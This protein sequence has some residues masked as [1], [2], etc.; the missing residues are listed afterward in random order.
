[1]KGRSGAILLIP[2]LFLLSGLS[3]PAR[4]ATLAEVDSLLRGA[5]AE[6]KKESGDRAAKFQA[7]IDKAREALELLEK[8]QGLSE[9]AR[10]KKGTE[11]MSMIYWSRKMK[12]LDLSGRELAS[13]SKTDVKPTRTTGPPGGGETQTKG[14]PPEKQTEFDRLTFERA[15]KYA[16]R[17]PEDLEGILLRFEGI[18]ASYPKTKW[19]KKA[20]EEAE[21]SRK[22]LQA[23]RK[24]VL[25][26][27]QKQIERLE[28][29]EAL[30]ALDSDIA[31]ERNASRKAQL[32]RLKKDVAALESCWQR[33]VKGLEALLMTMHHPL[34]ELGIDRKGWILRGGKKGVEVAMR[35]RNA[36]P[37][38]MTW[39]D[40]GAAPTVRLGKKLLNMKDPD[41]IESLAIGS[42]VV[43]DFMLAHEMFEKLLPLAPERIARVV[44]YFERAQTGYRSS[45]EGGAKIRFDEAKKLVRRRRYP[46]AMAIVNEL[47]NDLAKN[48]SLRDYL[49]EV[50]DF[51]RKTMRKYRIDDAGRPINAF[52]KKVR[53]LFGGDVKLDENNAEIE[54][55]YDFE[56]KG[57]LR[58]WMIALQFGQP[59][60]KG[61][62]TI[63]KGK[64]YC[65]GRG[66][67]LMWRFPV[68]EWDLQADITY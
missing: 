20:A 61:G 67:Y 13:K 4:G 12:P 1:M 28:L 3:R 35:S 49:R 51:R 59:T 19:G 38:L 2:F 39:Q 21:S 11:I 25:A 17:H 46:E 23:A 18:A 52:Q 44:G 40:L 30:A 45:A 56:D 47:R 36:P 63:M 14:A 66:T 8:V 55:V 7:A 9:E 15:Q 22:K 54:V 32:G 42:T 5:G 37:I 60:L 34:E 41:D 48:S 26:A 57:Q 43:G 29:N 53:K 31:K 68:S 16:K 50:N 65:L 24:A 6:L 27:R 33:V 62:W 10:D 58:D 64:A